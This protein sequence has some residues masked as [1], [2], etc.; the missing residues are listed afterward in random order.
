[1]RLGLWTHSQAGRPDQAAG[2][3]RP[4]GLPVDAVLESGCDWLSCYIPTGSSDAPSPAPRRA[5]WL[6]ELFHRAEGSLVKP[7]GKTHSLP[8]SC[9]DSTQ[10]N[11]TITHSALS[12]VLSDGLGLGTEG[13][14]DDRECIRAGRSCQGRLLPLGLSPLPP[15]SLPTH[16]CWVGLV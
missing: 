4:A 8:S 5:G 15:G 14:S 7:E 6:P 1:M 13:F 16:L 11:L 10:Q 3:A 12:P 2:E 9:F